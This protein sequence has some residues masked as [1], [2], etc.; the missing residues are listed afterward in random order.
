M[1][2]QA[3]RGQHVPVVLD[4]EGGEEHNP[5]RGAGRGPGVAQSAVQ[6]DPQPSHS[7]RAL[8]EDAGEIQH[9]GHPARAIRRRHPGAGF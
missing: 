5:D 3:G 6:V 2:L 9:A 7:D 8:G 1:G 4:A